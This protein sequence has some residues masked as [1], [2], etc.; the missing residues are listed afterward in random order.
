[1]LQYSEIKSTL[2]SVK[3]A[4]KKNDS[5]KALSLIDELLSSPYFQGVSIVS[6]MG[7]EEVR[8]QLDGS[9][10]LNGASPAQL[11]ELAEA[12]GE[13]GCTE[14]ISELAEVYLDKIQ[15]SA[16][17]LVEYP[18]YTDE[19]PSP[20]IE[21]L[22][23]WVQNLDVVGGKITTDFLYWKAGTPISDIYTWFDAI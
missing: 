20:L 16:D 22:R 1:M 15:T 23:S 19:V 8:G 2:L 6:L 3:Q 18:V 5:P 21:K 11:N 17:F 7:V 13:P 14:T 10:I 9:Y 12:Y 4:I